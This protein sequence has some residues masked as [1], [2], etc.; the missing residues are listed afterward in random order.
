MVGWKMT[1]PFEMVQNFLGKHSFLLIWGSWTYVCKYMGKPTRLF[2]TQLTKYCCLFAELASTSG[3][4]CYQY[5]L[6]SQ[7]ARQKRII[8]CINCIF[9]SYWLFI[10]YVIVPFWLLSEDL[11][12]MSSS[13]PKD[14]SE[15]LPVNRAVVVW[16]SIISLRYKNLGNTDYPVIWKILGL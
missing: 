10:V 1:F 8:T 11:M 14:L 5:A 15:K 2:A 9:H 4:S 7:T 3:K 16:Y 13:S 12:D 6:K